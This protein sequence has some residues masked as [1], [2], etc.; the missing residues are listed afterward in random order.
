MHANRRHK[1]QGHR[2]PSRRRVAITV[3]F[4]TILLCLLLAPALWFHELHAGFDADSGGATARGFDDSAT[5]DNL[6]HAF[7]SGGATHRRGAAALTASDAATDGFSPFSGASTG[8]DRLVGIEANHDLDGN[9]IH[10]DELALNR[11]PA[12][13]GDLLG[14]SDVLPPGALPFSQGTGQFASGDWTLGDIFGPG[15]SS[16]GSAPGYF[17]GGNGPSNSNGKSGDSS[18]GTPARGPDANDHTGSN[19]PGAGGGGNAGG[20]GTANVGN[21]GTGGDNG[22]GNGGNDANAGDNGNGGNSG[23][24][25]NGG[26]DGIAGNGGNGGNGGGGNDFVFLP[27]DVLT[28]PHDDGDGGNDGGVSPFPIVTDGSPTIFTDD[29]PDGPGDGPQNLSVESIVDPVPVPE[30]TS[31]VLLGSGLVVVGRSLRRRLRRRS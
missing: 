15:G 9:G 17:P 13:L 23:N 18:N 7:E 11:P 10:V 22:N 29:T 8:L 27:N 21:P 1:T 4:F 20:G 25:G 14:Q 28:G 6:V 3:A 19:D 31:L 5:D 30:P 26:N 16:G 24:D 2:K 12:G